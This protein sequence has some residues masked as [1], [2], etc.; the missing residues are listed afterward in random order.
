MAWESFETIQKRYPFHSSALQG[1]L[2]GLEPG[3]QVGI[4]GLTDA[5]THAH[6]SRITGGAVV[7]LENS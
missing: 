5:I 2:T 7:L 1:H 6:G 3:A 4:E